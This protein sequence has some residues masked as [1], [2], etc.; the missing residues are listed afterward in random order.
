MDDW[1]AK[2]EQLLA[3]REQWWESVAKQRHEVET[4]RDALQARIDA[5]LAAIVGG[6]EFGLTKPGALHAVRVALLGDQAEVP[7][8]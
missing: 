3:Q 4:E 7:R 8:G 2:Y 5:A 1:Q 6:T